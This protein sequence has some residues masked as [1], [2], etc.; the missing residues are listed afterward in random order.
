MSDDARLNAREVVRVSWWMA[1]LLAG[2]ISAPAFPQSPV[3]HPSDEALPP[4]FPRPG[5][6]KLLENRRVVLWDVAWLKQRYPLHRHRCD[7]VV[8]FYTD[9]ERAITERDGTR[10][11]VSAKAWEVRFTPAGRV[12]VEEGMSDPPLRA[13]FMELKERATPRETNSSTAS[14]PASLPSALESTLGPALIDNPRTRVW[15]VPG[16]ALGR[17]HRHTRDAVL[18]SFTEGKPRTTFVRAGTD[19]GGQAAERGD[20]LYVLE[21]K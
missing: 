1:A 6:T 20:R 13:V 10:Q 2:A 18:V 7:L 5:V 12:H 9:G 11:L 21:V 16:D 17:R 14:P 8:A 4:A 3:S 15:L 19:H